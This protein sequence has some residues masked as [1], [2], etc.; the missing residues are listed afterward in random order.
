MD[1]LTLGSIYA[2]IALGYTLVYGVL[3]L[4][5][6]AHSEIFALGHLRH[7]VRHPGAGHRRA[8]AAG[9]PLVGTLLVLLAVGDGHLGRSPRSLMERIAYRRLR[10]RNA[11]RLTALITAIGISLMLQELLAL[12]YGRARI[13]SER[14]LEKSTLF[15]FQGAQI[16][17]DKVLVFVSALVLMVAARPV[18]EPKPPRAAASA[19]PPRTPR[20]RS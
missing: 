14:V 4:I 3:R 18:R 8:R 2:L 16:R 9:S 15:T 20:R 1:G 17:T 5:N 12:R 10:R 7:D 6:F 11:P 13:G 19:P